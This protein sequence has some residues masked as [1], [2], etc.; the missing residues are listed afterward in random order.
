VGDEFFRCLVKHVAQAF[1][2]E[3]AFVAEVIPD[4]REHAR[5]L[6][7]WEGE[8]LAEP[9]EYCMAGTPCAEVGAADVVSHVDGVIER[10]PEDEMVV[11]MG[12]DSYLAVAMRGSDGGHL[13][14]LGVLASGPLAPDEARIAALR[15]FAA[16]AA[17]EV[18]RRQH[19]RRLEESERAHR[20]LAEQLAASRTRIV[21]AGD[22]ERRRIE[23]NLHDGAQQ[24][25]VSLALQLRLAE[26]AVPRDLPAAG[27]LTR[28]SEELAAAMRELQELARGIHPAVLSDRGLDAALEALAIRAPVP[29]EVIATPGERLPA[30]VE[31]TVY[32][33]VAEA[34]TNV[35]KYARATHATVSV[36]RHGDALRFEV[37]DD[38]IGGA[39]VAA[40]SGLR[41]LHDR[42]AAVRGELHIDSP[43]GQGTVLAGK[44]P[45]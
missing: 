7:C 15:I 11:Q 5:F 38:G 34:L 27:A 36:S 45:L 44:I 1:E 14:H 25:L 35:A 20:E 22:A 41:G 8:G 3:V 31:A 43:A 21:E 26:A 37:A 30:P 13:G 23:R 12:L 32:F 10:F 28:A 19:E 24:R 42:V 2:A 29:V 39:D 17:A 18:E 4:D 6:A 40:G 16:R 9:V 33:V